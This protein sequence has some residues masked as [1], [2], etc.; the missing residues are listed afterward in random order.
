MTNYKNIIK[1]IFFLSFLFFIPYE[2]YSQNLNTKESDKTTSADSVKKAIMVYHINPDID[3]VYSKPEKFQFFKYGVYDFVTNSKNTFQKKNITKISLMT[4]ATALFIAF[5]QQIFDAAQDFG[6]KINLS[7][8]NYQKTMISIGGFPIF[9]GPTDLGTA[10]YFL[11]DGWIHTTIC[12]SYFCYGLIKDDNRALQTASQLAEGLIST[13]IIHYTL[14][15]ITGRES[16]WVATAPGGVWR[17]FPDPIEYQKHTP[18]YDAFPSGH[19][20]TA[21]MTVTV[22]SENYAEYKFI[23]PLGYTLMTLLSYQMINNGVHWISDYPLALAIGYY[24]AKSAVNRGRKVVNK[25]ENVQTSEKNRDLKSFSISPFYD[26]RGRIGIT[27]NY[28]LR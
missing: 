16:P 10:L 1:K 13:L 6:D 3:F 28:K 21:M 22:I 23:R 27:L 19:L 14:K 5:D 25:N 26:A 18:H 17:L 7:H 4:V 9:Q 24:F 8:N 2:S 15:H 11:G 12:G 20:A